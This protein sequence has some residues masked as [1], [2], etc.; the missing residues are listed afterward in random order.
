MATKRPE[1]EEWDLDYVSASAPAD[2]TMPKRAAKLPTQNGPA[3]RAVFAYLLDEAS[4]P[5]APEP[6]P[7]KKRRR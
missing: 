1:P 6:E 3:M 4:P 2:Q 7:T 5:P